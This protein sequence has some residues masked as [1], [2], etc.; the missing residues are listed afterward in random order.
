MNTDTVTTSELFE[1]LTKATRDA[2]WDWDL[3]TNSIWWNEGYFVLFGYASSDEQ[4]KGLDEWT[5]RIHPTDRERVI[6]GIQRVIDRLGT[7]WS[8]EYQF[9]RV[10]GTYATVFDRGYILHRD[11]KAV[12]MVGSMQ[13]ISER[14]ALQ[15]AQQ[16]SEERLRF[17]MES[18]QLGTWELN[19]TEGTVK[20]DDRCKSIFGLANYTTI[21]YY[22]TLQYIHPDDRRRIEEATQWALNPQ[23]GGYYDVRYRMIGEDDSRLRWIHSIGRTY[24][25]EEGHAYRF[26]GVAQDITAET[27]AREKA[28]LSEQQAKMAIEGSGAGAFSVDLATNAII[29][30]PSCARILTGD[31]TRGLTREMLLEHVHPEDRLNRQRAYEDGVATGAITYEARF[32][33]N[34]SSIHWVKLIGQ[35]LF[36]ALGKPVTFSGIALDITEQKEKARALREA[37]ERFSIAFAN[38]SVGMAFTDQQ[39]NFSIVNEAYTK[40]LGYTTEELCALNSFELTHPD[41]RDYNRKLFDEVVQG[42]RPSFNLVKRYIH[43]EG[44]FRWVQM[45]VTRLIDTQAPDQSMVIIAYDITEQVEAQDK[46]KASEEQFRNMVIQAPVAIS[47]LNSRDMTITIAND[48]MLEIWGKDSSVIGLPLIKGLPELEGQ[49]FIE[50]LEGVF[51]SGIAYY[52]FETLARLHRQGRLDEAYFNFVYAPVRNDAKNVSGVMVIATEVT[53][54]VKAKRA[55]EASEQRFRDLIEEASVAISLFVGPDMIVELPNEKMLRFW[56]KD[57]TAIGKPLREAVPELVGQPFLHILEEVYRTGIEYSAQEAPA[58]LF[59]DGK[60]STYYFNFTYKP[61]RD[62]DGQIYAVVDMAIDVTEQVVARRAIEESELRFRTLMEAISQMTWTNTPEGQ[63]NFY[64]QQWYKYTGLNFSEP[65]MWGWQAVI[66]PDDL[67]HTLAAFEK[68]LTNGTIFVVEN[69][70]RRGSDG[71]YRWHLNRALPIR[72]ES[73]DISLWVGTATDIH[74]QKQLE[75]ELEQQVQARTEQLVTSNQDLRRSND[76]LE[77]FAYIASH[78]L[79]EPLRKI[80]SFGDILKAQYSSQIGEGLDYLER[81]QTAAGRMSLLIRDLLAFSRISTRQENVAV[82]S[83]NQ[84]ITDV[85]DD[86]EVAV[87]QTGAQIQVDKL[88]AIF[89][90]ASQLRQLFQNLLSNALKF[91][92]AGRVPVIQIQ[93][94][95]VTASLLPVKPARLAATYHR[96]SVSDNGIGFD[97]KY[98]DRI[99]Q[100]FQ[101]LHGRNEYVGTGIGLAICEKVVANHGGVITAVSQPG[102]GATFLIYLPVE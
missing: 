77:K 14:I 92:K 6:T 102:Q 97:E 79:Q 26:S 19:P 78:D 86:L 10:D 73:G 12:R 7:N 85:L 98:L 18:A 8:D 80:Q 60:L 53:A 88:P 68:A 39:A 49:G 61:L 100:V 5:N 58:E 93:T 47:I 91:Q 66:H 43:K 52:G 34:D 27:L 11:G 64:N 17:A 56:G 82:V 89:G 46:L 62:T 3:E 25:D 20:W 54:Q 74:E 95:N 101:R 9:R 84:V 96:I 30:S 51:D 42:K 94:E 33:W 72:D 71:M 76:N 44:S 28:I 40:L 13:D 36:D 75:A 38:T 99:F 22:Q 15:Q 2:V 55:L 70:Y 41:D 35:Y 29:Y 16:E 65:K 21:D 45:N 37:E 24:F 32:I 57:E 87:K 67:P 90:D 1:L 50:L 4:R 59:V 83:L 23:S 31:E 81:M 69:R 63:I 48:S